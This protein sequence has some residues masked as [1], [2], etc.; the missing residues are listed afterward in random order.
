M[1]TTKSQI[2]Q[3]KWV[4]NLLE[5]NYLDLGFSCN[6]HKNLMDFQK[7]NLKNST[8]LHRSQLEKK[9]NNKIEEVFR[10]KNSL[11]CLIGKL[12]I[13]SQWLSLNQSPF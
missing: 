3:I 5:E 9:K 10:Q 7:D 2:L 1:D 12:E 11:K 6:F 13:I 8:Q 4:D